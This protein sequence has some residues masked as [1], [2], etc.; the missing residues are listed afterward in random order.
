MSNFGNKSGD[1]YGID[2]H[3]LIYHVSRVAK[4]LETG[5]V[6][7]IYMEISPSGACNHR[8]TFCG[9]DFMGYQ[10]RFLDSGILK[11]RLSEMGQ[12][13]V[14][15]IMYGGEG[16]PLMHVDICDI[17]RHTADCSIDVAVTSNGVL[18][19]G[20]IAEAALPV[21]KW[22]KISL[23]AGTR[24]TYA[25]VHRTKPEDF[26]IVLKNIADAVV[27]KQR[28]GYTSTIGVQMLL[29]PENQEE[30]VEFA[31]IVRDTGAD[32]LVIKPYSQHPMSKTDKYSDINYAGS[33]A[34]AESLAEIA[35]EDFS[36]IFRTNAMSRWDDKGRSYCQCLAHPFWSYIDTAGNCWGCSVYLGDERF[37]YGNIYD[38][39][40]KEIWTGGLRKKI[41]TWIETGLDVSGCR[42]NCRMD[43]INRYLW[44]LKHQPEHVNFI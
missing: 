23:N 39:S 13:G 21:L 38:S 17:I 9:L 10:K 12:L 4:W 22:I 34:L 1:K 43:A 5:D 24:Q 36:V 28:H 32:Y 31:R 33:M 37:L 20:A 6:Y 8:C 11:E 40:F 7:P 42:V 41:S 44:A 2:S 27:I 3:K 25:K 14:R 15:S 26:D 35:T 16:E 18:F 30:A 19:K 29:L